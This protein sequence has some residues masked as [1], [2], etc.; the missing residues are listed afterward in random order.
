MGTDNKILRH[1]RNLPDWYDLKKYEG[2]KYLNSA[3]WYELL[4][5]RHAHLIYLEIN[6]IEFYGKDKNIILDTLIA[7]RNNPLYLLNDDE[8]IFLFGG[9]KLDAL[10]NDINSFNDMSFGIAPIT[11][12]RL[13]QIESWY[14][15]EIKLRLRKWVDQLLKGKIGVG[16]GFKSEEETNFIKSFIHEP[17]SSSL[18]KHGSTSMGD[19]S[20]ELSKRGAQ[21]V[22]IDFRLPDQ[23]LLQQFKQ[24]LSDYRQKFPDSSESGNY[25]YPDFN[26]WIDFGILPFLDL[27]IWQLQTSK[28]IPYRVLADAIYPTG[29]KGEEMVRKTTQKIAKTVMSFQYLDFFSTIV[30]QENRK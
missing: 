13:F 12:M 5:Q 9:G 29:E 30:A 1:A 27:K 14:D 22:E 3:A 16:K 18:K 7:S 2:L 4:L 10:K 8:E 11:L 21:F 23:A 25:K 19:I 20:L 26:K 17:I 28:K 15:E 6:G 24:H